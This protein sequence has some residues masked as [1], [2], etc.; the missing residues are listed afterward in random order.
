MSTTNLRKEHEAMRRLSITGIVLAGNYAV[1]SSA[2][3]GC[4]RVQCLGHDPR[5]ICGFCDPQLALALMPVLPV[6]LASDLLGFDFW[7]PIRT[8]AG[9]FSAIFGTTFALYGLG[10]LLG[11]TTTALRRRW[12]HPAL[13]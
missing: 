2:A 10:W 9:Y 3:F 12:A 13:Q 8:L 7:A 4:N 6:T 11:K 5:C 1:L